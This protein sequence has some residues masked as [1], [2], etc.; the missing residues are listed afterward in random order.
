MIVGFKKLSP[1][2]KPFEYSRPGDACMDMFALDYT[3]LFSHRP[4]LI[5]TGIAVEIPDGYEGIVRGRSGYALMHN[6]I[7]HVGTI[8]SAYR[9]DVSIIATL[10][11]D[12][13]FP[14][15]VIPKHARIGQFSIHPI[16]K[17]NLIERQL[18]E[19]ERGDQGFGSSGF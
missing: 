7:V 11:S 16:T 5:K 9:G 3:K 15:I 8:E 18:S 17:I 6:I 10:I 2:A 4:T 19:T 13:D 12:K 1:D 14:S